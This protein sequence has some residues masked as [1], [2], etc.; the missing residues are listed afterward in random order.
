MSEAAK[1]QITITRVSHTGDV[2]MKIKNVLAIAQCPQGQIVDCASL[3]YFPSR[4]RDT[5]YDAYLMRNNF[6]HILITKGRTDK[7]TLTGIDL[8]S[9]AHIPIYAPAESH[10]KARR[11]EMFLF[12]DAL[13]TFYLRL[14][15]VRHMVKNHSDS[16]RGN[17]LPPHRLLFLINS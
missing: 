17:P 11:K 5:I 3:K 12:N 15:G 7:Q 9:T 14:Y 10:A 13:S 4:I 6:Q 16:E 2:V 1:V 8:R